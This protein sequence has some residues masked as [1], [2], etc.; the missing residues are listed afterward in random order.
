[1]T[2]A[3]CDNSDSACMPATNEKPPLSSIHSLRAISLDLRSPKKSIGSFDLLTNNKGICVS[4]S[5]KSQSPLFVSFVRRSFVSCYHHGHWTMRK[6]TTSLPASRQDLLL[7]AILD[8]QRP[9]LFCPARCWGPVLQPAIR[10]GGLIFIAGVI[11]GGIGGRANI[12]AMM[13]GR[14]G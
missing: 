2:W 1:M 10:Q 3:T 12:I 4:D 11:R 6:V 8:H 13:S 14:R 5:L 7:N 9:E